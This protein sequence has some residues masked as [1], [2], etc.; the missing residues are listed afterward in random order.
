MVQ[1]KSTTPNR[2][3][4]AVCLPRLWDASF[5]QCTSRSLACHYA[6]VLEEMSNVFPKELPHHNPPA[7]YQGP[8][9]TPAVV[10]TWMPP[11]AQVTLQASQMGLASMA[12]W[13]SDTS[14]APVGDQTTGFCMALSDD[15]SHRHHLMPPQLLQRLRPRLA[16]DSSPG[17]EMTLNSVASIPFALACPLPPS[18][19]QICSSPQSVNSSTLLS[20]SF[21][22]P[23]CYPLTTMVSAL[24]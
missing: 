6:E 1:T 21:T 4:T 11:W 20:L 19:L 10:R 2:K 17:P 24:G 15:R 18:P 12:A 8:L 16:R 23:P 3:D 22:S 7:A 5:L 9:T 14:L 13:A